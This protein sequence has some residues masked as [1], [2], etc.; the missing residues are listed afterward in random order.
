ML[1]MSTT[2]SEL[3]VFNTKLYEEKNYWIEKLSREIGISNLKL[4]YERLEDYSRKDEVVE[5]KLSGLMHQRLMTVTNASSFLLYAILLT[6]LKVC[7]HKYTGNDTIVVGS[8][9]LKEANKTNALAIVD[10]ISD[11]MPFRELLLNVRATLLEA[12]SKQH[13]PFNRLVKDLGLRNMW[14]RCP[15]FDMVLILTDIHGDIPDVRNDITM[16]LTQ[17]VDNIS[18]YIEYSS[19]LFRQD[20]IKLFKDHFVHIL[21]EALE[22]VDALICEFRMSTEAENHRLLAE[23]NET[24]TIYPKEVCIHQLFEKQVIQTPEAVAAVFSSTRPGQKGNEQITYDELNRRANQVAHHLQKLDV[25]PGVLVGICMERSLEMVIGLLGVLKAGSAYVPFDPAYPK[26]RLAFMLED[27]Q[28]KVMLTQQ[29]LWDKELFEPR[30]HTICLDTD[31]TIIA[32]K[33]EENPVNRTTSDNLAYAIYTSGS[34]G[35][36]KGVLITHQALVNYTLDAIK[37]FGL[38]SNDRF[39]QFAPLSFDVSVEEIFPTWLSGATLILTDESQLAFCMDLQQLIE[40]ENMTA[41]ELP[42]VYWHEWINQ[43]SLANKYP[44]AT[45]RFVIICGEKVSPKRLVAWQ[46][47]GISLIH[48]YGLTEATI[49]STL[50]KLPACTG[51]PHPLSVLPVGRPFAN[52]KIYILNPHLQLVPVGVPGELYL[53]TESLAQGYLNRPDLTAERFIPNPFDQTPGSRLYKTGDTACYLPDGDLEFLGRIDRQVKIRGYRIELGEIEATLSRYSA[54]QEAIVLARN[55]EQPPGDKRLVAYVVS[56][57]GYSLTTKQL[58]NYLI[59]QLPAYMLPSVFVLLGALPLTPNGKI[60]HHALPPPE[61]I[62]PD[63]ETPF[64]PPRTPIEEQLAHTWVEIL[65]VTQVG[66]YDD[67]FVLG[68]H[69]LLATQVISRVRDIF[70]LELPQRSLFE[71]STIAGLAEQ[72]ERIHWAEQGLKTLPDTELTNYEEAEL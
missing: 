41:M 70:Q 59:Q 64:I 3:F 24:Q 21:H 39:L 55:A 28:V 18:G 69:S 4:Y 56:N 49:T 46:Q 23:W 6:T 5:L 8:P 61:Q 11:Q 65:G 9:A 26:K 16:V 12:Y 71:T 57:A 63:I 19:K 43:L 13:Y 67:F 72:I 54:V 52:T 7:L 68:G 50:Y 10:D 17:E 38:Q 62:R 1:T 20:S 32:R 42:T 31:W 15:L 29:Q 2:N 66:I 35:K 34:T 44:P 36:P 14:N 27:T 47:F 45:L 58:R 40:Q 51:N 33:S 60:D 30:T 53:S 48:V 37:Q 22:N 25:G